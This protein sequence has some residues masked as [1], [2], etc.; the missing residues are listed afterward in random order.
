[1]VNA[2]TIDVEEYFCYAYPN[3]SLSCEQWEEL[4]SRVVPHTL[5]TLDILEQHRIRAT[6]FLLGWVAEREPFLVREI[7]GRGHEISSHGY[8]HELVYRLS[9][10]Q[11][12]DDVRRSIDVIADVTGEMPA[13]YRAPAFSITADCPW[14][15]DILA[16]LGFRYDASI[17]PI[18]H[19]HYGIPDAPIGPF[20]LPTGMWEFPACT[21]HIAG[22]RV[23]FGGGGY[24]RLYPFAITRWMTHRINSGGRP[25]IIY[26]HPWEMD[27]RPPMRP[28][29][30]ISRFL[31]T[32][33]LD[34]TR[35]RLMHLCA[36]FRFAPVGTVLEQFQA[37]NGEALQVALPASLAAVSTV[38]TY[39]T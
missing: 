34:K 17:Y 3:D 38:T 4:E 5:E 39:L 22:L 9:P 35:P 28:R 27:P 20:R 15:L 30:A 13:G 32:V 24:L 1:M 7:Q 31:H 18:R 26:V 10:Q 8:S 16:E 21:L 2:L 14:A 23:P 11:F 37:R 19:R 25:A 36:D 29:G 33:N 12:R 6:F